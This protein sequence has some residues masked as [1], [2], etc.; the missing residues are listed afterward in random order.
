MPISKLDLLKWSALIA[1]LIGATVC[2]PGREPVRVLLEGDMGALLE[3]AGRRFERHHPS[4][5]IQLVAWE[6]DQAGSSAASDLAATPDLPRLESL[7]RRTGLDRYVIFLGDQLVLAC[8]KGILKDAGNDWPDQVL[9]HSYG[10]PDP[11]L[12]PVG[13]HVRLAWKLAEDHYG[14]PGLYRSLLSRQSASA[15]LTAESLA[16]E[17]STGRLDLAF[18]YASTAHRL[19]LEVLPLPPEVSLAE[20]AYRDFYHR[21]FLNR[22]GEEGERIGAPIRYGLALLQPSKPG[23]REFHDFLLTSESREVF[24]ALGYRTVSLQ[25]VVVRDR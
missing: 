14:R 7:L 23:A 4:L 17:L 22:D 5:S 10:S 12:D 1:V 24:R 18:L 11:S 3:D 6:K 21:A 13:V 8:R 2:L 20:D 16:R 25:E 19:N 9:T 15:G